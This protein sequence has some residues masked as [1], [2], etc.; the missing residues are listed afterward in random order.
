LSNDPFHNDVPNPPEDENNKINAITTPS[1]RKPFPPLSDRWTNIE[2]TILEHTH[3]HIRGL[4]GPSPEKI[5]PTKLAEAF[6][7]VYETSELKEKAEDEGME[8]KEF[9]VEEV[10]D[11]IVALRKI[12][13]RR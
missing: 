7:R 4:G 13:D 6:I 8:K 1:P 5:D 3:D 12:R 9:T 2:W 11:R 10:R